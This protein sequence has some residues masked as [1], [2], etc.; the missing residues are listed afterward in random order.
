MFISKLINIIEEYDRYG[1]HRINGLKAVYSLMMLF[2]VNM[3]YSIPN[4]YFNYFYIPLTA[5]GAEIVGVTVKHKY[6]LFFYTV[7]GSIISVFLFNIT[8]I[9]PL[10][11]LLFVFFY[12]LTLYLLAIHVSRN[13]LVPVPL[14][15][16]LAVYSLSNGQINTNFYIALNNSLITLLAMLVIMVSMLFFPLSYYLRA[17][18]RAFRLMLKQV[19]ANFELILRNEQD[20]E[21]IQPHLLMMVKF[22][23]LLPR[24]SP[25]FNILKINLLMNDLRLISSVEQSCSK[26]DI[27][28]MITGLR[29]LINAVEANQECPLNISHEPLLIK[30]IMC[31]NK[32]CRKI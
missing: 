17:W 5:L 7:A 2:F 6:L 3:V 23:R 8:I 26:V 29:Y 19:L 20:T 14:I 13:L 18:L 21:L 4:P 25:R 27:E 24:K 16:S 11:F 31:W 15:L 12:S 1:E 32:L 30:I 28:Q 22:A 10:V 9:Y